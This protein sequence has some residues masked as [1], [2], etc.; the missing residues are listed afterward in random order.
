MIVQIERSPSI[1]WPVLP[2]ECDS[3][4]EC[5][6]ASL[7][8]RLEYAFQP[9]VNIH[10]GSVFG[11]EALLRGLDRIGFPS[12]DRLF[13]AADANGTLLPLDSALRDKAIETFARIPIIHDARLLFNLDSR[14][15]A[16]EPCWGEITEASLKRHGLST[17]DICFELTELHDIAAHP[18]AQHAV[19]RLRQQRFLLAID[20][21]GTGYSGLKLL[22]EFP[23]DLIKID[24]FFVS[25]IAK[26]HKRRLFVENAVHLAH[27]LGIQVVAE[28]VETADELNACRD[29]G[30]DLAQGFFI[31][32]PTTLDSQLKASY[33]I[34]PTTVGPSRRKSDSD[35]DL[36]RRKVER[37]PT[38]CE[39][40]DMRAVYEFFKRHINCS[41]FPI[42][43]RTGK[44]MGLICE[45]DIKP[46]IYS[47]Y[48]RELLSNRAY[49]KRLVD[50]LS[51][52]PSIDINNPIER[53]LE[54]YTLAGSPPGMIMTEGFAYVGFISQAALLQIIETKNLAAA[55]DQNPL[56]RLPGN[57]SIID[58][59]QQVL[60]IEGQA[61][62]L[63]YFDFD[64][65]KPFNDT[66]GFRIGDRAIA[67]FADLMRKL[68]PTHSCF[69][70]HIGG[71]DFFA[72]F[73][74]PD[75]ELVHSYV[76]R[77]LAQFK[78]EAQSLY[79]SATRE[80]G[81]IEAT[82]RDGQLTRLPLLGCSAAM[83]WVPPN[84]RACHLDHF[85]RVIARLKKNAKQS[86]LGLAEATLEPALPPV[87][88]T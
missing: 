18:E 71:D 49:R 46:F 15:L 67:L 34:V 75:H 35:S 65:F 52:C 83:L 3:F 48:G 84:A 1:Q 53:L 87:T 63:V 13:A 81:Y 8:E 73:L 30:C 6:V 51:P 70:G 14:S 22:Y 5:S 62:C 23:P 11:F 12:V 43:D 33:P 24:R 32:R 19:E 37:I 88:H 66:Y 44:P 26:D 9:V 40:E 17:A 28:G 31:A 68:L 77:L 80:R 54:A 64:N 36:I 58:Y 25:S 69:I 16:H 72:G 21:F 74:E 61:A 41:Y 78:H 39:D 57:H 45:K 60:D 55:R 42:L 50:F 10:T 29:I 4:K 76:T 56:T 2:D 82:T 79:D 20:D 59:V 38:L 7:C 85:S 27:T 47:A 86:P